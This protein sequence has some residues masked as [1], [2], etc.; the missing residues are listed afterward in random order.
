M[1]NSR[2]R[3]HVE[4][5]RKSCVTETT[6]VMMISFNNFDIMEKCILA[7]LDSSIYHNLQQIVI[8]SPD[9][10]ANHSEWKYIFILFA[11]LKLLASE[12]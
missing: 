3:I 2:L 9:I 8:I 12:Q 4:L 10:L 1:H 5:N 7:H 11:I 6:Q